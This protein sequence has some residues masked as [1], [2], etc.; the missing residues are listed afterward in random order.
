MSYISVALFSGFV[1]ELL[2][3]GT[4]ARWGGMIDCYFDDDEK[5]ELVVLAT[6]ATLVTSF[7]IIYL[8]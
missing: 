6:L 8:S 1:N 5:D 3:G 7:E 4:C 2:V